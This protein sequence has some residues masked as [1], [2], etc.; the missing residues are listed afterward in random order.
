VAISTY[1]LLGHVQHLD[2]PTNDPIPH[3]ELAIWIGVLEAVA[4]VGLVLGVLSF[5]SARP[6]DRV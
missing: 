2:G 4:L 5:W 1:N 3:L 6:L